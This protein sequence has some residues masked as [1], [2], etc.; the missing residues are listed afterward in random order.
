MTHAINDEA[1][2]TI[3]RD[4]RT[5]N[6]WRDEPVSPALLM[7]VYDLMRWGPTTA[8]TSPAR[9]VFLVSKEARER[10]KPHLSPGNRDKTMA[11]PVTAIIA[12]DLGFPETLPKLFPHEPGAK[13]WFR[14]AKFAETAAFRNGSIQGG[15][16]IIAARALGL[17]CG[18][19][20][21]FDNAGVD[22]EFFPEGTVKS[23][24]LCNLGHG[25]PTGV[26][27]RNPRM[28]FDEACRIL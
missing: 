17:D 18:P 14:D 15:Y 12:Y 7:A 20:S 19:M 11:A 2:A 23:N 6:R 10:L 21:G 22:R 3:F 24:F 5:H 13:G 28:S 4:A 9:I 26:F 8:N 25:D 16:F 27:P 1:L